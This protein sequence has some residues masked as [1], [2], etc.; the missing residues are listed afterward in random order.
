MELSLAGVQ[1]NFRFL[2]LEVT[3]QLDGARRVLERYDRD[4]VDSIKARDD[5]ADNLK[6]II[7]RKCFA[8]TRASDASDKSLTEWLRA[9]DVSTSNL[10]RIADFCV[11]V[12]RQ[13]THLINREFIHNYDFRGPLAEIA[14]S[15][16]LVVDAL[17]HR[18]VK[19]ALAI[20]R[21]EFTLDRVYQETFA[22]IVAELKT[23]QNIED[24]LTTLFVFR[25][26]ER[27]GDA[28]L[29]IGEAIISAAVGERLKIHQYQALEESLEAS[30][31]ELTRS[32]LSVEPLAETRSGC[33]V[34]RVDERRSAPGAHPSVI[35]KEGQRSKLL[36]ERDSLQRWAEV[37]P[38]LVP[39]VYAFHEH[40]ENASVLL[41]F[42][43]GQTL[44]EVVLHREPAGLFAALGALA[45]T[46]ET[47]WVKTRANGPLVAGYIQQ[48]EARLEDVYRVHPE[49]REWRGRIGT[50]EIPPL[51]EMLAAARPVEE[52]VLSPFTVL[53]HGDLNT[54]N[55]IYDESKRSVHFIDVHRSS[56]KDYLQDISVFLVS[57]FR[58]PIF[59]KRL[60]ERLNL[61][62]TKFYDFTRDFAHRAGDSLFEPRIALGVARSFMT[63]TRFT[64]DAPFAKEMYQ[65]ARYLLE[66]LLEHAATHGDMQ[67]FQFPA[68]IL[69]YD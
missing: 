65:R 8:L 54:D 23:G 24:L 56:H 14:Q 53:V 31:L 15:L 27:A 42:L 49:F 67:R 58:L 3:R 1:E 45:S 22:K 66:K 38:G 37:I 32:S 46:L 39:H 55:I 6:T 62:N 59:E 26:F 30:K 28:L 33:S 19:K 7:E 43:R 18:D 57:N 35:F 51:E 20:C 25:Y 47:I 40:G 60:R 41:E 63:S 10:E 12:V 69:T 17:F 36:Q 61:V 16:A 11:N 13:A 21:C 4:L 9:L 29:N 68:Q 44:Q 52:R 5:Y 50:L 34:G 48:I 2:V 64:L